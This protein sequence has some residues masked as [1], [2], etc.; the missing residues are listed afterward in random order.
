[1]RDPEWNS[2]KQVCNLLM[3]EEDARALK[4]KDGAEVWLTTQAS[5]VKVPVE[6]SHIPPQGTVVLPTVSDLCTEGKPME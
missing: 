3:N 5:R 6:V 4:I 1:M 2:R